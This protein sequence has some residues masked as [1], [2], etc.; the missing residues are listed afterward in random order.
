MSEQKKND[1]ALNM[2]SER[3]LTEMADKLL[4][5]GNAPTD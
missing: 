4:A 3:E 5:E 1:D 2:L